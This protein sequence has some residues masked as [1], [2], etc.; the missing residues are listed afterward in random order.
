[1]FR[2]KKT[3]TSLLVLLLVLSF[4]PVGLFLIKQA[5][6]FRPR[7]AGE[8][9]QLGEG[10]C[11]R[12]NKD[13]QKAVD[14]SL[15][16][17]KITNPFFN[18]NAVNPS[19]GGQS[20]SP[21][22]TTGR[23]VR[24]SG[25]SD[26][27]I[28]TA[29]D[30]IK[31]TGGAV[32][33]PAGAYQ[34][35]KKIRVFS[36]TTMFGDGIDQTILLA[37]GQFQSGKEAMVSND[38]TGGLRNIAVR[39]MTLNGGLTPQA[40]K[41]EGN[42]GIK[43]RDLTGGYV[44]N[45]KVMQFGDHGIWLNYKPTDTAPGYKAVYDVRVTNCQSLRNKGAGIWIDSGERNVVD[46]CIV[47]A[48]GD[49]NGIGYEIGIDG[50]LSNNLMISN[51]IQRN[52]HGISLTAGN[53]DNFSPG[54]I[55]S[56]NIV[57]YN[58]VK[59]N[60]G[61][62]VW[63]Q[64]GKDNV[65]IG[66]EISNN[67][68]NDGHKDVINV[69]SFGYEEKLPPATDPR[70]NIPSSMNIPAAP[71]KTSA[72]RETK[73]ANKDRSFVKD[74]LAQTT[75]NP[76]SDKLL[77][78][79]A[80]SQAGLEQAQWKE[81]AFLPTQ[82]NLAS[83]GALQTLS[84]LINAFLSKVNPFVYAVDSDDVFLNREASSSSTP[85]SSGTPTFNIGPQFINTSFQ[86]AGTQIGAK[87]IWVELLHP[88]GTTRIDNVNFNLV[89][90]PP[91]ILGLSCNLDIS[92]ENLK[93]TIEGA[94]L[95]SGV[96]SVELVSPQAKPEVLGWNSSQIT[97]FLKKPNIP[98]NEGQR[99]KFKVTRLDGFE[100]EVAVCAVDKSLVS[101]GA[102]IFCREAG[103]F[104]ASD[105]LVNLLYNPSDPSDPDKLNKVEEK[106]TINASGEV[107]NLK[108]KLQVGKNYA[109][110]IKAPSSL[111]RS[112][113]FIAQEG[114]TQ[115][116]QPDG[117][118]FILPIGDI[119]PPVSPDG[120]INTLDRAE[121]IRQWRILGNESTKQTGDFNRD[122]RVNSI[123]WACMNYDFG[124][125]DDPIPTSVPQSASGSIHIPGGEETIVI[126]S[127]ASPAPTGSISPE[128][129]PSKDTS[130]SV[131]IDIGGKLFLD[132][133]RNKIADIGE[134][135]ISQGLAV[136]RLLQVPEDHVV[137]TSLTADELGDSRIL[138]QVTN[139]LPGANY[140]ISVFVDKDSGTKFS[141]LATANSGQ[142]EGTV[143]FALGPPLTNSSLVINIPVSSPTQ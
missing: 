131:K 77:Y 101:L 31:D 74:V 64:R 71:A 24:V 118:P 8:L 39:D 112:T 98:I 107:G 137:G 84:V 46:H 116:T 127:S 108:T 60:R 29:L 130:N 86:L 40:D 94:R 90:K 138:A 44:A 12:I 22:S 11:I 26:T 66:N 133:N 121:L 15:V 106:V 28:Q 122:S 47:S 6:I 57:C 109:V 142:L 23:T 65:Y 82:T 119:A 51:D 37:T 36:N 9:I 104:D 63:D 125:E 45:V 135:F 2:D 102:R 76:G 10:G 83:N 32:Y 52:G 27:A 92:K 62:G 1:M 100:S 34:I 19:A 17:L 80:E 79:L 97:A 143:D 115:I 113:T 81:F 88:D 55:N 70:C 25:N 128:P 123:D 13:K 61:P 105:V 21:A 139:N 91:Q 56:S 4:I 42:D 50:R 124:K 5:Q 85:G 33:L 78:R 3:V 68:N 54:M 75:G 110:A 111:R 43:F 134:S 114:T 129:S 38:S 69:N 89:E 73:L 59:N 35:S 72:L 16:P 18:I 67:N 132:T 41:L 20:P 95:G 99:F 7:A 93:I 140:D 103:K 120:R 48:E 141:L 87:Q 49:A 30:S 96:G 14:C 53:F 136:V 126:P 117:T 58:I